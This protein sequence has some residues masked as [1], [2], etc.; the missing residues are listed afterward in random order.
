MVIGLFFKLLIVD[1][2]YKRELNKS[3]SCA[4]FISDYVP[5]VFLVLVVGITCVKTHLLTY[6]AV[7]TEDSYRQFHSLRQRKAQLLFRIL[8]GLQFLLL[9]LRYMNT[10]YRKLMNQFMDFP[11]YIQYSIFSSMKL[12]FTAVLIY[13][14]W[15]LRRNIS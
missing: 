13:S 12:A 7:D 14:L 9:I 8:Q 5:Q 11:T 10:C 6:I 3:R 4:M 2:F 15:R 1:T